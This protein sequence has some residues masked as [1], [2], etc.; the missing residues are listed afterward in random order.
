VVTS[1][2][3]QPEHLQF[4]LVLLPCVVTVHI[5]LANMRGE[6][7]LITAEWRDGCKPILAH[8]RAS[9]LI[10]VAFLTLAENDFRTSMWPWAVFAL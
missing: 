6:L 1:F 4:L 7:V 2:T 3:R 5:A 8:L 10:I 9:S